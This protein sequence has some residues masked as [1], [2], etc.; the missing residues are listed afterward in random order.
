MHR[1]LSNALIVHTL[2]EAHGLWLQDGVIGLLSH[3][4]L[5]PRAIVS[6][7]GCC[8]KLMARRPWRI[9]HS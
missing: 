3:A 5:W 7:A 8:A 2:S 6:A 1:Q 9:A 4:G